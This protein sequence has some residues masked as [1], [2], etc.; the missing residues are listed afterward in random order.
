MDQTSHSV[1][2]LK[3]I[4]DIR[5]GGDIQRQM[6]CQ[7]TTYRDT[8][9]GWTFNP[10]WQRTRSPGLAEWYLRRHA[11]VEKLLQDLSQM[12]LADLLSKET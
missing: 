5:I 12:P 2:R 11:E 3:E 7:S 4:L 8:F 9:C 6:G 10:E 1:Q